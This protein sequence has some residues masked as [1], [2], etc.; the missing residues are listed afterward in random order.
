M[1]Q[2]LFCFRN[3][4]EFYNCLKLETLKNVGICSAFR[5]DDFAGFVLLGIGINQFFRVFFIGEIFR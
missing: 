4:G 3:F 2:N 5:F 1:S